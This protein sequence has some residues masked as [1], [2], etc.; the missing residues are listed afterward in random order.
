MVGVDNASIQAAAALLFQ[1]PASFAQIICNVCEEC[2]WRSSSGKF[3][4]L[5]SVMAS[6]LPIDSI[7][8]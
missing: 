7:Y 5:V 8:H 4:N 3:V 2:V 1:I 6:I